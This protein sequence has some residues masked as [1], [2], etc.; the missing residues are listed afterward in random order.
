[1]N[2]K[3]FIKETERPL[4]PPEGK[5]DMDVVDK[6]I[7]QNP[8]PY[9]DKYLEIRMKEHDWLVDFL[10]DTHHD[11]YMAWVEKKLSPEQIDAEEYIQSKWLNKYMEENA[12][13]VN[14]W[15]LNSQS[16]MEWAEEEYMRE[17]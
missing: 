13:I 9:I 6:D 11:S 15:L 4:N 17:E 8:L 1:M 10:V 3:Q 12:G 5:H 2:F 14:E 7:R 16:F